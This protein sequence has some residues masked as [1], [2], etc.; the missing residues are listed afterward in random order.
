M[1]L[2]VR[3]GRVG[4]RGRGQ[5]AYEGG[6]DHAHALIAREETQRPQHAQQAH[7]LEGAGDDEEDLVRVRARVRGWG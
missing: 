3:R 5:R 2:E 4:V 6:E 7:A 1:G